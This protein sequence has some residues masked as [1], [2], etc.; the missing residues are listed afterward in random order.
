MDT[1]KAAIIKVK[2]PAM[3]TK[4]ALDTAAVLQDATA[5]SKA[6]LVVLLRVLVAV[7]YL[8]KRG[9]VQDSYS[10]RLEGA[11]LVR[12]RSTARTFPN[13]K[14]AKAPIPEPQKYVKELPFW[15]LFGGFGPLFLH[16]FGLQVSKDQLE[17]PLSKPQGIRRYFQ[18]PWPKPLAELSNP[19]NCS[20]TTV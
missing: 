12:L 10:R 15:V 14:F 16:K 2:T 20:N 5:A 6:I 4:R 18:N 13:K 11:V 19:S 1:R 7:G 3:F 9:G 17:S 8:Q